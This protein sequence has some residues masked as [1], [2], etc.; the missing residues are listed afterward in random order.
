VRE[1]AC[2]RAIDIA[3]ETVTTRTCWISL[4]TMAGST[5]LEIEDDGRCKAAAALACTDSRIACTRWEESWRSD[6]DSSANS[7]CACA[8]AL[9][10]RVQQTE[11]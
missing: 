5:S 3:Q 2:R 6:Q 8:S 7:V 1:G 4:P 11:R 9:R 10:H